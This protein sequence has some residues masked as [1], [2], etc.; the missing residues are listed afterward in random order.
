[1]YFSRAS[2]PSSPLVAV[3]V[4]FI[5]P[6]AAL[7]APLVFLSHSARVCVSLD[8][9]ESTYYIPLLLL[10]ALRRLLAISSSLR[11]GSQDIYQRFTSEEGPR[12]VTGKLGLDRQP[13]ELSDDVPYDPFKL[14]VF[15]IGNLICCELHANYSN[16]TM[17]ELLMQRMT[18]PDSAQRLTAAEAYHLFK[19]IHRK[20]PTLYKYWYLQPRDS[21]LLARAVHAALSLVYALY[22]SIF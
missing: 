12:L 19:E 7:V 10:C 5:V 9:F 15:L 17:L 11:P 14:D 21:V 3:A 13:P 22:R 4:A 6:V 16:L 2:R 8:L 20:V 1:M 18:H